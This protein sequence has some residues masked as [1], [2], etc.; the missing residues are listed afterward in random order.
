MV[1][2][3]TYDLPGNTNRKLHGQIFVREKPQDVAGAG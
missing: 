3:I 2:R 1:N